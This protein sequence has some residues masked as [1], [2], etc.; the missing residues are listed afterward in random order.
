MAKRAFAATQR[1]V[2]PSNDWAEVAVCFFPKSSKTN[3][4][5][6]LAGALHP[7][8]QKDVENVLERRRPARRRGPSERLGLATV[9]EGFARAV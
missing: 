6:H 4:W 5:R 2:F 1:S 7:G 8:S 9:I 3:G